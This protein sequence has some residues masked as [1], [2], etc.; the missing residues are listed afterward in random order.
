MR[1]RTAVRR[2]GEEGRKSVSRRRVAVG[3]AVGEGG[4]GNKRERMSGVAVGAQTVPPLGSS[5]R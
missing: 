4:G 3:D 5:R 2:Q 1:D